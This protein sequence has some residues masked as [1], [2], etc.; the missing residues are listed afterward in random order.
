MIFIIKEKDIQKQTQRLIELSCKM[1]GEYS[2]KELALKIVE[3][4][5]GTLKER[6][7]LHF[8]LKN[9]LIKDL[10]FQYVD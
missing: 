3:D 7:T 5:I 10:H 1:H 4:K 2:I 9:D 8:M 6:A